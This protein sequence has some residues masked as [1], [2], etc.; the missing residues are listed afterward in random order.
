MNSFG[1]NLSVLRLMKG[2]KQAE[3]ADIVGVGKVTWSD[4]ERGKSEP[5]LDLLITIADYFKLD[6]DTL[7]RKNLTGLSE[8]EILKLTNRSSGSIAEKEDLLIDNL[9]SRILSLEDRV[10]ELEKKS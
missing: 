10:K 9:K 4:Y 2:L 6:L 1:N 8:T 7:I 5:S 3:I